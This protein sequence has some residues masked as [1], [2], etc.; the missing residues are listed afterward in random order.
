MPVKMNWSRRSQPKL[1]PS[2]PLSASVL[3]ANPFQ[4]TCRA[5]ASSSP[6]PPI[7]PAADR[8]N[9]EAR[10]GHYRDSGGHPTSMESH[11]DGAGEVYL[12]RV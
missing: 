8:L 4:N 3:H 12:P 1:Q 2:K 5:S 6:L 10:R 9:Y 11:S 7:A